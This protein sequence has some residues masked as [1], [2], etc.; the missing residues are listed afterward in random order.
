MILLTIFVHNFLVFVIWTC[1]NK[2]E[3]RKEMVRM[4]L[5]GKTVILRSANK[6]VNPHDP[7]FQVLS[8]RNY[9]LFVLL[10]TINTYWQFL[11]KCM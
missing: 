10:V 2:T 4:K 9:L 7:I 3:G 1:G 5:P 11:A 6:N 8:T